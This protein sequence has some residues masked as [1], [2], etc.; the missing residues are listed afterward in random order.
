MEKGA[1]GVILRVA[2]QQAGEGGE[3]GGLGSGRK[4]R[5]FRVHSGLER[6]RGWTRIG[7]PQAHLLPAPWGFQGSPLL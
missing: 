2:M 1:Q 7:P 4:E 5:T 6:L 3:N